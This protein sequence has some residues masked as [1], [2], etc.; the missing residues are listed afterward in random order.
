MA[1]S[2]SPLPPIAPAIAEWP[3]KLIMVKARPETRAGMASGISTLRM[4]WKL[5]EPIALAATS[6]PGS[7]SDRADS[8]RRATKGAAAME[9]GIIAATGPMLVNKPRQ[10]DQE[11]HQYNEGDRAEQV[12]DPGAYAV[13]DRT[14]GKAGRGSYIQVR[15]QRKAQNT[16]KKS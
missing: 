9:R 15:S 6:T 3:I 14:G 10:G 5:V 4:I 1:R 7:I 13:E 12:H 2:P 16:G 8:T 11:Y